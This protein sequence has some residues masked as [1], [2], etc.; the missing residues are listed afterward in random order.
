MKRY[1]KRKFISIR[2]LIF[3]KSMYLKVLVIDIGMLIGIKGFNYK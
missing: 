1:L 3:S 2:M